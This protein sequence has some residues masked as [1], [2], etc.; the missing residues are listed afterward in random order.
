M[1]NCDHK[2][3]EKKE[4]VESKIES[5]SETDKSNLRSLV[6]SIRK[7]DMTDNHNDNNSNIHNEPKK[8]NNY[9]STNNN[10]TFGSNGSSTE[11]PCHETNIINSLEKISHFF[12][13]SSSV[14]IK[15]E[16]CKKEILQFHLN[17][18]TELEKYP[19]FHND[20]TAIKHVA[21]LEIEASKKKELDNIVIEFEN[22]RINSPNP[23]LFVAEMKNFFQH[24]D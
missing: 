19:N 16:K 15:I 13:S 22:R 12:N 2:N 9:C 18:R 6:E 24:F 1:K 5:T 17:L 8:F 21:H 20:S 23:F 10:N 14:M 11:I 3:E 4:I 7:C